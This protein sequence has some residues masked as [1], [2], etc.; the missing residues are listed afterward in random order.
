MEWI[1]ALQVAIDFMEEHL[2]EQIEV[3]DVA[4]AVYL[5]PFYFQKGFKLITSYTIGEYIRN[6]RLY[7]AALEVVKGKERVIDLA[8]KYGYDTP[9]SF[10][11]AFTRF[12]GQ[13]P[14]K[15]KKEPY[16]M[17]VFL[18]LQISLSIKG[19]EKLEYRIE[20]MEAFE[21]IGLERT[22]EYEKAFDEIPIFWRECKQGYGNWCDQR[23]DEA[24]EEIY[25][26]SVDENMEGKYFVY[27][28]A[29]RLK[30]E[31]LKLENRKLPNLKIKQIP[32]LTWAKFSC[33]GPMPEALQTLNTKIFK[34]WLP[35]NL[36]Y[37]IAAGYNVELYTKG[38]IRSR[39]YH[40]EIWVPVK[41]KLPNRSRK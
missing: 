8:Y 26:I 35:T 13:S 7:L 33:T 2:L 17:N 24:Q 5:S 18:P 23:I 10:T 15:I 20:E 37:E 38:D 39:E 28:I 6:R 30:E 1:E 29:K 22:F 11:K 9:E 25:G 32:A 3:E 19:G 41:K 4:N 12:H 34:E 14:V 40:S 21:I 31:N 27:S 16:K 36:T